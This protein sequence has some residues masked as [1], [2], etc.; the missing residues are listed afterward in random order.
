MNQTVVDIIREIGTDECVAEL[1]AKI[2]AENVI[3]VETLTDE[4]PRKTGMRIDPSERYD[5]RP[6][7][8]ALAV[9]SADALSSRRQFILDGGCAGERDEDGRLYQYAILI[10]R[11]TVRR[12]VKH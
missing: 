1:E 11:E 10:S 5:T 3:T 8:K 4:A 2:V 12:G 6:V 7:V 9:M